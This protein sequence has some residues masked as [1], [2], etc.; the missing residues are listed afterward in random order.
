[1]HNL[2]KKIAV[3]IF[4]L[5]KS[6]YLHFKQMIQ[7]SLNGGGTT[8]NNFNDTYLAIFLEN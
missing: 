1:M 4:S 5:L 8:P 7:I 3:Y 2:E 6:W